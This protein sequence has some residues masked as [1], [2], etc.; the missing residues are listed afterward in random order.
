MHMHAQQIC[1]LPK[2]H[3]GH[4]YIHACMHT[5]MCLTRICWSC[6]KDIYACIHTYIHTHVQVFTTYASGTYHDILINSWQAR[7]FKENLLAP[8]NSKKIECSLQRAALQDFAGFLLKKTNADGGVEEAQ[9]FQDKLKYAYLCCG[10]HVFDVH[11]LAHVFHGQMV[12]AK[13]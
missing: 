5:R 4:T 12:V 8:F 3:I 2:E 7:K 10:L 11:V 6:Q 13:S 1:V 9:L